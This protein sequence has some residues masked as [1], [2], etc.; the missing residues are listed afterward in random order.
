MSVVLPPRGPTHHRQIWMAAILWRMDGAPQ[1]DLFRTFEAVARKGTFTAAAGALDLS[2]STV[3]RHIALLEEESGAP[4]LTRG[5]TVE[6]TERGRSLLEAIGP[7]VS[8]A[9]A[10]R[11]ALTSEPEVEG[12]ITLTTVGEVL[13]W[14]LA[15]RLGDLYR[16][17]P[18]LRLRV[19]A[20]NQVHSLAA[21]EADMALRM[22]RPAR[23]ELVSRR[24][25]KESFGFFAG[26]ALELGKATPWLGLTGSLSRIPEQAHA[27]RAFA[28]RPARLLVEDLEALGMAAHAGLGVAVLP[29][30]FAAR[31]DTLV[32][33]RPS[34]VGAKELGPIPTRAVYLVIHR[35][36]ARLPTIRAVARW[37][38]G[39]F[40]AL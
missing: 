6:L 4:L 7:M 34:A 11:T 40:K 16:V 25:G 27:A 32:E 33:V 2:Q 31:F 8:A 13:R 3:S 39:V 17:Y 1:W 35:A 5:K 18:R 21:N 14:V 37:L 24:L 30:R 12:E 23:G 22:L 29:R 28:G 10:A 15:P 9:T 19:L 36:K 26:R 20:D 38:E